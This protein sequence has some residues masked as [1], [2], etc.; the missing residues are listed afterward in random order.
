MPVISRTRLQC[1]QAVAMHLN[2]LLTGTATAGASATIDLALSHRGGGDDFYN[3][4]EITITSGAREGDTRLITDY[5]DASG[6]ATVA[7]WTSTPGATSV[8]ELHRVGNGWPSYA[9]YNAA[10]DEAIQ[11]IALSALV[12]AEDHTICLEKG[13]HFYDVPSLSAGN[14][15]YISELWADNETLGGD[16]HFSYEYDSDQNLRQS[17]NDERVGQG[18]QISADR[19]QDGE[20]FDGVYIMMRSV[21]TLDTGR[22]DDL[23]CEFYT[24]AANDR[25]SGTLVHAP[26]GSVAGATS[27]TVTHAP[28]SSSYKFIFFEFT[29][30]FFLLH[31]TTYHWVVRGVNNDTADTNIF[32][33][34]AIDTDNQYSYG[35]LTAAEVDGG[36]PTWADINSAGS[37][38]IFRLRPYHPRSYKLLQNSWDIERR[39]TRQIVLNAPQDGQILR[40]VGQRTTTVPTTDTTSLDVDASRLAW[41]AAGLLAPQ[42][43]R[44]SGRGSQ[45]DA[46]YLVRKAE[47]ARSELLVVPHPGA[48]QVETQ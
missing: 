36:T 44:Q 20:W 37:D 22:E 16:R 4:W 24:N 45:V 21:G 2:D 27:S 3:G 8:Y 17:A 26:S 18:F 11:Q 13:K 30:P 43:P 7:A 48:R 28:F 46:D 9:D 19:G 47:L 10:I 6:R 31:D 12:D 5:A 29:T 42:V 15:A 14:W 25:P 23:L 40:V 38:A 39:S 32:H 41:I 35:H 34:I 33:Q 1:R